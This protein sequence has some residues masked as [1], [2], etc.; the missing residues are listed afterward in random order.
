MRL[1]RSAPDGP[2]DDAMI[3][4]KYD[5]RQ[6]DSARSVGFNGIHRSLRDTAERILL[7]S[8]EVER[9]F[10]AAGWHDP[11]ELHDAAY[12]HGLCGDRFADRLLGY[13]YCYLAH[14]AEAG[15]EPDIS[16]C[17][18]VAEWLGNVP[19]LRADEDWVVNLIWDGN[20]SLSR[21]CSYA[22][23]VACLA[24]LRD[25]HLRRR[26]AEI[27]DLLR[28]ADG[29]YDRAIGTSRQPNTVTSIPR[30]LQRGGRRHG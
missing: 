26:L 11:I 23:G 20:A 4:Q 30:R 5:A 22:A 13:V 17:I 29:V 3:Q 15:R 28:D 9:R 14:C 6:V 18:A 24:D 19:L 7:R 10:V 16:E 27:D 2:G 25:K 1:A 12:R 8:I 21:T